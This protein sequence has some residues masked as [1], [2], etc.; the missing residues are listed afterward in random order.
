MI[1]K[2]EFIKPGLYS[3]LQ[4]LGRTGFRQLAIPHGG[5]M[6]SLSA[7][8]ANQLLNNPLDAPV[9]E[10]T[11]IAPT[12]LFH[13][14][15]QIGLSGAKGEVIFNGEA[16][17]I[18]RIVNIIRGDILSFR[19]SKGQRLYLAVKNGFDADSFFGS[20][21]PIAGLQE[22]MR[23]AKGDFLTYEVGE[24]VEEKNSFVKPE[25]WTKRIACFEG[26][27]FQLLNST[28][29]ILLENHPFSIQPNHTRMAFPLNADR[30]EL[31]HEH[32]ILT[33]PV[34]PGVVQLTPSGQLIVLMRDAQTTGGYPRVLMLPEN[35]INQLAQKRVG[36]EFQWELI[37]SE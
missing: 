7:I 13:Q 1:G 11:Q 37:Q 16:T 3:S 24:E 32:S 2:I 29:K 5:A 19:F 6:D 9:L 25:I 27:E 28:Q 14:N 33:A 10:M 12:L 21:S 15:C 26:P 30:K 34:V 18:K 8:R 35:S 23:F 17:P 4:D 22:K 20:C 31:V 36:E